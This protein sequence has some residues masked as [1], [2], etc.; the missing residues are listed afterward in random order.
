MSQ[1]VSLRSRMTHGIMKLLTLVLP[2][3]EEAAKMASESL[4]GPLGFGKRLGL[5]IHLALCKRCRSYEQ[6]LNMMHATIRQNAKQEDPELMPLT[7]TLSQ[8]C[9]QRLKEIC[10]SDNT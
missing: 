1:K 4:D 3:C 9:R 8:S 7:T 2:S 5:R 6:Q 10:T